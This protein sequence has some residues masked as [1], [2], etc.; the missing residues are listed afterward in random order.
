MN[1]RKL[2]YL[3]LLVIVTGVQQPISERQWIKFV[4]TLTLQYDL[5]Q[6]EETHPEIISAEYINV[7][8]PFP[9]MSHMVRN[10][11]TEF[12][13]RYQEYAEDVQ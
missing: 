10:T 7:R 1:N 4:K 11:M 6:T 9:K 13:H 5:N 8:E 12:V 2:I 3:I